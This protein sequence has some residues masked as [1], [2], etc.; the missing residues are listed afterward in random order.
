MNIRV[1]AIISATRTST[2]TSTSME[3]NGE[4]RIE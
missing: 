3:E 2:S 1:Y 4:R